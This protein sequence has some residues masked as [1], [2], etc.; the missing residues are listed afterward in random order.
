MI[1]F[2]FK[3]IYLNGRIRVIG[4]FVCKG[5]SS[6]M[7]WG[8]NIARKSIFILRLFRGSII[9]YPTVSDRSSKNL[10]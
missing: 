3:N 2:F 9:K 6:E 8:K 5:T 7:N 1:P 10:N 4:Y